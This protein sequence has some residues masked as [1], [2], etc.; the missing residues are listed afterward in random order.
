MRMKKE[1][2]ANR[3]KEVQNGERDTLRRWDP[4][5]RESTQTADLGR[6]QADCE[7]G[8]GNVED[9]QPTNLERWY[10]GRRLCGIRLISVP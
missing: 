7:Q 4:C 1:E 2:D 5:W 3:K 10:T 8:E 9:C 6:P